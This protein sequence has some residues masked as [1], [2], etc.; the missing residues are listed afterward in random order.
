MN[1]NNAT[2]KIDLTKNINT[3]KDYNFTVFH[4]EN[5]NN[6]LNNNE[7]NKKYRIITGIIKYSY[8]NNQNYLNHQDHL[9]F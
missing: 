2:S 5:N 3:T 7:S 9:L 4:Y 6:N 1:T 8:I